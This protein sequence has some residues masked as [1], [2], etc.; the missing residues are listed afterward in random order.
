MN[1]E[2]IKKKHPDQWVLVRVLRKNELG[3][4]IEGEIMAHSKNR[5]EIYEKMKN[6][7]GHTYTLYTGK[8]PKK[9]YAVAF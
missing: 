3:Q 5:D 2:E 8:I 9:G 1:V 4:L 7:K 6:V